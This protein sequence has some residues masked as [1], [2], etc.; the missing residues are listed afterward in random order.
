M[1]DAR[2][3]RIRLRRLR[4]GDLR[5][6]Q[7]YR[8]DPQVARYQGWEAM[9]DARAAEFIAW[10]A[11][12]PPFPTGWWQIGIARMPEDELIGDLGLCLSA[13]GC[14]IELGITLARAAQGAGLAEEA[15]HLATRMVWD[16]TEA[17]RIVVNTDARNAPALAL[18]ARLGLDP[19]G[20]LRDGPA[21]EQVF[22]MRRPATRRSR[23]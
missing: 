2:P 12:T 23:G 6:F 3:D 16:G 13:D 17:Q 1:T 10:N 9:D 7:A 18:I 15:V 8:A 5:A 20:T 21:V 14:E 11:E 22:E 4:A 19:A